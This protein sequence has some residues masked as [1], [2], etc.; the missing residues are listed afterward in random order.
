MTSVGR[1]GEMRAIMQALFSMNI[2]GPNKPKHLTATKAISLGF[3]EYGCLEV[4]SKLSF[5]KAAP[6]ASYQ[7]PSITSGR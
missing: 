2:L 4:F 3:S 1:A 6:A 7:S 5:G